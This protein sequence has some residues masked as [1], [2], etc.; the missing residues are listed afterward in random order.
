MNITV[1]ALLYPESSY[2]LSRTGS[3]RT[4]RQFALTTGAT[5]AGLHISNKGFKVFRGF[6]DGTRESPWTPATWP[7]P[8]V[9]GATRTSTAPRFLS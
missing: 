3:G 7:E 5:F 1:V 4:A 9:S 2:A 6:A 8:A